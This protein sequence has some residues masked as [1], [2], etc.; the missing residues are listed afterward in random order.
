MCYLCLSRMVG[1]LFQNPLAFLSRHWKNNRSSV[2]I[3]FFSTHRRPTFDRRPIIFFSHPLSLFIFM[4]ASISITIALFSSPFQ[5]SETAHFEHFPIHHMMPY[6][7]PCHLLSAADSLSCSFTSC[8]IRPIWN[9]FSC[10]L[11]RS[12]ANDQRFSPLGNE[13]VKYIPGKTMVLADT[14]SRLPN[15][16]NNAEIELDVRVM[17]S[18]SWSMTRSA[19]RLH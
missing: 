12:A 4:F 9:I 11:S 15:P 8:I 10:F 6:S 13:K 7:M 19:K 16:E 3:Y 17:A 18:I 2:D 14:L 1:L 5:F